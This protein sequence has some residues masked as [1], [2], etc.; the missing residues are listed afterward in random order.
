MSPFLG[1]AGPPPQARRQ[2]DQTTSQP[3]P[4]AIDLTL[5]CRIASQSIAPLTLDRVPSTLAALYYIVGVRAAQAQAIKK[6]A[7]LA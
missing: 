2:H 7:H 1:S 5:I 3:P 6:A 4:V